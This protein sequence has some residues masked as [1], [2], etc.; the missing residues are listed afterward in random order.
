MRFG[1]AVLADAPIL[2]SVGISNLAASLQTAL[3]NW[4]ASVTVAPKAAEKDGSEDEEKE[5][6]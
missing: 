3:N 6:K 2:Q 5:A 1:K 4:V